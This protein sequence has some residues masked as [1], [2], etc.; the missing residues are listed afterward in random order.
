MAT[1]ATILE[2]QHERFAALNRAEGRSRRKTAAL[3]RIWN[4]VYPG[5][6][7]GRAHEICWA[8]FRAL[9]HLS[10]ERLPGPA[11]VSTVV[12]ALAK[13]G[14]VPRYDA[15]IATIAGWAKGAPRALDVPGSAWRGYEQRRRAL[16]QA[17]AESAVELGRVSQT[18]RRFA[19]GALGLS[20][21]IPL[22]AHAR[23]DV[24]FGLSASTDGRRILLA[25]R[26]WRFWDASNNTLAYL[27]LVAHEAAH[28]LAGSFDRGRVEWATGLLR[29]MGGRAAGGDPTTDDEVAPYLE[30]GRDADEAPFAAAARLMRNPGLFLWLLNVIEDHRCETWLAR[31][32]RRLLR[33]SRW[34]DGVAA[35]YDQPHPALLTATENLGKAIADLLSGRPAFYPIA[36]RYEGLWTALEEVAADHARAPTRDVGASIILAAE[37]HD[38]LAE[39]LPRGAD[40]LAALDVEVDRSFVSVQMSSADTIEDESEDGR[41]QDLHLGREADRSEG[42]QVWRY[43]EV[44]FDG[45][46]E[47]DA[48]HVYEEPEPQD[49][50]RGGLVGRGRALP[51]RRASEGDELHLD[52][53]YDL[54]AARASGRPA[55]ERVFVVRRGARPTHR[56]IVSFLVDLTTS[57]GRE[58]DGS[59]RAIDL[60]RE[61]IGRRA[62]E[63][64][65][66]GVDTAVFGVVDAGRKEIR[67]HMLKSPDADAPGGWLARLEPVGGGGFR[68]GAAVRHWAHRMAE[69]W[70]EAEHTLVLAMDTT[71]HYLERGMEKRWSQCAACPQR[72][73]GCESDPSAPDGF[74]V[75]GKGTYLTTLY[76]MRDLARAIQDIGRPVFGIVTGDRY[77]DATLSRTFGEGRWERARDMNGVSTQWRVLGRAPGA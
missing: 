7:V 10:R 75:D 71:S 31:R 35:E 40:A 51:A 44:G 1:A 5:L 26:M 69:R 16:V 50:P 24:A 12:T 6:Q 28:I 19:I 77:R 64:E 23:H 46:L 25:R 20:P 68:H 3:L 39:N 57:M 30:A 47:P 14:S 45:E 33:L 37:V 58:V 54:V 8:V 41:A 42:R 43:P 2:R 63:L 62:R 38:L 32:D 17:Q 22:E 48:A 53:A 70:P 76:E 61:V 73:R 13:D 49:P 67:F 29:R 18:L 21:A 55:D 65:R 74:P 60:V 34:V 9:R 4:E 27:R 11:V 52:A 36:R 66:E 59:T 56:R 15:L 72:L